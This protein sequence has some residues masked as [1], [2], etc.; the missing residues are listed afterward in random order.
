MAVALTRCLLLHLHLLFLLLL[1]TV[2]FAMVTMTV[3]SV[4]F[5]GR[6]AEGTENLNP[7]PTLS[8]KLPAFSMRGTRSSRI[9]A[10]T[11]QAQASH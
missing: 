8:H 7:K 1:T 4:R 3:A 9:S 10:R 11:P 6:R 2:L 5:S